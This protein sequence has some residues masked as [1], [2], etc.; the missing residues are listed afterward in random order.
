MSLLESLI[1]E[2]DQ[3]IQAKAGA[4]A[5]ADALAQA[6]GKTNNALG[7]ESKGYA[8]DGKCTDSNF[9]GTVY[10]TESAVYSQIVGDIIPRANQKIAELNARIQAEIEAERERERQRM[11]MARRGI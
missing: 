10:T 7:I 8:V 2:R 1:R 5:T 3:Y 11:L 4:K 6:K 9:L